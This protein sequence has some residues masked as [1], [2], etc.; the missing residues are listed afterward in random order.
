L[1]HRSS[2][3]LPNTASREPTRVSW[4]TQNSRQSTAGA[5]DTEPASLG[6]QSMIELGQSKLQPYFDFPLDDWQL[7]AGG[8]VLAGYNVIVSAPTG[9]GKTVA[10]EMALRV[11]YTMQGKHA[12]YT[13]PLKALSNQKYADL[14]PMFGK[15]HVGLSTGDISI[16]K[17]A[18]VTVMTTEVYRNIAWRASS[19]RTKEQDGQ[20]IRRKSDDNDLTENAVVVLDEFHYMGHPGRGGVWEESVITSPAHTQIVGLSATLPNAPQLASWM[21]HV[22]GRKTVLVNISGTKPRPVPLR[23]LFA[24]KEGLFPLFRDPEAGPGA[25]K[26]LLGL[27]GDGL[28]YNSKGGKLTNGKK[29]NAEDDANVKL[30]RGLHVNPQLKAAAEKRLQKVNR[31][32]ERKKVRQ[33]RDEY[34]DEEESIYRERDWGVGRGKRR[35]MPKRTMS[36]RD[37]KRERERMLKQELRRSVPSLPV[38]LKRLDQKDMLPAIF[39]LFSRAGCEEAARNACNFMQGPTRDMSDRSPSDPFD[40]DQPR[41][42]RLS[43]QRGRRRDDDD[44]GPFED[45]DSEIVRDA[46]GRMFRLSNNYVDDDILEASINEMFEGEGGIIDEEDPLNKKYFQLYAKSGLLSYKEI[47]TVAGKI[48]TFNSE[49]PEIA[50]PNNIIMQY[51]FGVGC[52]HAGMLPSHKSFVEI[53][54]RNQLMKAVFATETLAA[55]INMPARTT[56]I[57]ALAKRGDGSSMNLLETSNLL[58]MAGRAGRRGFDDNGYCV[59]VSTPF[60][61]HDD[62][63]KIL[64]DPIKPI[65]SQFSPSYSLAINLVARGQG[66]LDIAKQLVGKSF[67][68]W[69]KTQIEEEINAVVDTHGE[70]VSEILEAS[71]QER[72]MITLVESLQALIDLRSARFDISYVE[73]LLSI[74]NDRELLKKA[75]KSYLGAIKMLELEKST[76]GYLESELEAAQSG[77]KDDE[78]LRDLFDEDQNEVKK[79]IR[80]QTDRTVKIEK[81]IRKHPFTAVSDIANELMSDSNSREGRLL[82]IDLKSVREFDE[83]NSATQALLGP[84]DLCTFAKSAIVIRRKTRKFAAKN[85]EVDAAALLEQADKADEITND[86][87]EDMLAII[88][89]LV[90][91]GCLSI[92][93]P[94]DDDNFSFEK[95]TFEITPAGNNIGMLG[96]ENALW[97]LTAVGGAWDVVGA[98]SELDRS[99][100]LMNDAAANDTDWFDHD[101]GPNSKSVT[102]DIS[103]VQEEV[104]ELESLIRSMT[105]SQLAGYVSCLISEGNRGGGVSV[106]DV[107]QQMEPT[108]QRVIQSSL[109]VLE[110]L[111][112]VQTD[113]DVDEN[114]RVCNF[115]VSNC[116]VVTA[117]A[118]GCTWNEALTISGSP[119]GDLARNLSRVLDAVRQL[120]NLPYRALRKEDFDESVGGANTADF[121]RG[122]HPDI[123]SLCRDAARAINRYP[124]KDPL[125]FSEI[126]DE[127]EIDEL[128]DDEDGEL[129]SELGDI[130]IAS[131]QVDEV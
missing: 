13:T 92:H 47:E 50:F 14:C 72:F 122:I 15:T 43:R 104:R 70:G 7:Q 57:C 20:I 54:Y 11:A 37:E 76:L 25:P 111:M 125:Q 29:Q 40:S 101:I 19:G 44:D 23:Y 97:C 2:A 95:E 17:G 6:V 73:H 27:R 8:A 69:E 74:M 9:A 121:S 22:T 48:E 24:T 129:E 110:R 116:A 10:G 80:F 105:P 98:S 52:H 126:A 90:A 60:E 83:S 114:T 89:V 123:R 55:G 128:L 119:P 100:T 131:D 49:N 42:K 21:E 66:K 84:E 53:L 62:A 118:S 79:Q 108:Q 58:Q 67:A 85:P 39:F 28:V 34:R 12:I 93:S 51:M 61:N 86:T 59:I 38:L 130:D 1:I 33:I 106:I 41:K 18:P 117:W 120:G 94:L 71:A 78:L 63:A 99:R 64:T 91:Y 103:K 88:K 96:F 102:T 31:A 75:S 115:D 124:V 127:E 65:T 81:D 112:K 46:K 113:Y 109:Q 107:F 4:Q 3:F 35:P 87:W 45:D 5:A 77:D 26:G 82:L 16:N 56:V 32:I 30:P 68:L 36:P